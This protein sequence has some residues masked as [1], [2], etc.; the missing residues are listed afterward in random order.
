MSHQKR[1]KNPGD[2][3]S[4]LLSR[5][6]FLEAGHFDSLS[7]GLCHQI[8]QYL[9]VSAPL[10]VMDLGC[11]EGYF[12]R[13]ISSLLSIAGEFWGVDVAKPAI[14]MAAKTD[15]TGRYVVASNN[16]LPFM[17]G[18]FD[19][20]YSINAPVYEAELSRIMKQSGI[21]LRISPA[22]QHLIELKRLVYREPRNH[23]DDIMQFD[24]LSHVGRETINFDIRLG[25]GETFDLLSMT[26]YYWHASK[27]TQQ[28]IQNISSFQSPASFNID[29]Y[30]KR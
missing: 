25:E 6:R 26:P 14:Q 11:G 24:E 15:K 13:F 12:L 28:M 7:N 21:Y 16:D 17:D 23:D 8:A 10:K 29:L 20:I 22:G 2:S 5:R 4:M 19:V 30:Q 9:S 27:E 18:V 1:S 3:K